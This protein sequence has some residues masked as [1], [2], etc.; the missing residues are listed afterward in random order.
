MPHHGLQSGE[1]VG[2]SGLDPD[3]ASLAA[4]LGVKGLRYRS[5]A[6]PVPRRTA[7]P[8]VAIVQVAPLPAPRQAAPQPLVQAAVTAPVAAAPPPTAAFPLLSEALAASRVA[9]APVLPPAARPFAG[10]AAAI[11]ARRAAGG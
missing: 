11:A 4:R 9:V 6:R 7:E 10:L 5:F 8:V 3:I 1:R 2:V